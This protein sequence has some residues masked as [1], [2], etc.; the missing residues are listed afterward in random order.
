MASVTRAL[1][2]AIRSRAEE[3]ISLE[4]MLGE[5]YDR[6]AGGWWYRRSVERGIGS[7]VWIPESSWTAVP[8]LDSHKPA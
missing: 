2:E 5:G 7:V 8:P 4:L 6:S 3:V 1:G